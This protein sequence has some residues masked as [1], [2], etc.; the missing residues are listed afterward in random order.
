MQKQLDFQTGDDVA[1]VDFIF[2]NI[3]DAGI[4]PHQLVKTVLKYIFTA[5]SFQY[6]LNIDF[7]KGGT[8]EVRIYADYEAIMKVNANFI[9]I[10]DF[11]F[12]NKEYLSK[13]EEAAVN[14]LHTS[15]LVSDKFMMDKKYRVTGKTKDERAKSERPIL[16][17]FYANLRAKFKS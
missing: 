15:F 13:K 5:K 14:K 6:T 4:H 3:E 12:F 10:L 7:E 1:Q 11:R 9:Y 16:D 2:S 8:G 17:A